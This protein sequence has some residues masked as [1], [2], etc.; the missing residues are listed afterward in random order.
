MAGNIFFFSLYIAVFPG[1]L[2][3]TVPNIQGAFNKCTDKEESQVVL[4]SFTVNKTGPD[5]DPTAFCPYF[6]SRSTKVGPHLRASQALHH[7]LLLLLLF[8][9]SSKGTAEPRPSPRNRLASQE[10]DS[11]GRRGTS[12]SLFITIIAFTIYQTLCFPS[13]ALSHILLAPSF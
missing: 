9:C 12:D 8:L 2:L 6:C 1:P 10:K 13:N 3:S 7:L 11:V 4:F 5:R